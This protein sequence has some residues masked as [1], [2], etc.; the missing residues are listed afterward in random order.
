M[1]VGDVAPEGE[2]T[3]RPGEPAPDSVDGVG[4]DVAE[5]ALGDDREAAVRVELGGD[6]G[7]GSRAVVGS[8]GVYL[9]N[10]VVFAHR[11]H[12]L[13]RPPFARRHLGQ[14]GLDIDDVLAVAPG[15]PP[16]ARRQP[17][18]HLDHLAHLAAFD[19]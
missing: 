18:R 4:R 12:P 10:A 16:A 19:G 14:V 9:A 17:A 8:E 7:Q 11:V 6:R 13:E 3:E 2:A 1:Q 5:Q 15:E